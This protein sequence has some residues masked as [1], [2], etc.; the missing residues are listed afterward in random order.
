MPTACC[1]V[2]KLRRAIW[3]AGQSLHQQ[4]GVSTALCDWS[5]LFILDTAFA[6]TIMQAQATKIY[7]NTW[8]CYNI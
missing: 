7:I 2:V 8:A 1:G 4:E 5:G 6:I 3:L